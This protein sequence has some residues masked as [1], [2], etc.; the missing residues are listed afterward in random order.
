[1]SDRGRHQFIQAYVRRIRGKRSIRQRVGERVCGAPIGLNSTSG[2]GPAGRQGGRSDA[3][4]FL[5]ENARYLA[6]LER[7][8]DGAQVRGTILELERGSDAATATPSG[9]EREGPARSRASGSQNSITLGSTGRH[10][11]IGFQERGD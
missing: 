6:E 11:T 1:Q 10:H 9:G 3:V 8:G 2:S 5:S 7:R 4:E